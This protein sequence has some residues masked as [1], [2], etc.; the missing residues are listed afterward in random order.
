MTSLVKRLA[1][2]GPS[3]VARAVWRRAMRPWHCWRTSGAP[4]YRPPDERQLATIRADLSALGMP[5]VDYRVDPAAFAVF[6]ERFIFPADY[7]GGVD[8]PVYVEK[9]LEH[10]V[11]WDLLALDNQPGRWPYVDIA[12]ASSPWARLL[13]ERGR[14]AWSID[15]AP[16]PSLAQLP[17]YL[18]GDAT[19]SPFESGGLG[20][21]SLQCAF[22]M[23]AADADTRLVRELARVLKPNGRAVI[24]PLYMHVEACYYQSPE[25]YGR[26]IGDA[27]ARRYLRPEAWDVPVSRKYSAMTLEQRVWQPAIAA[28]LKPGLHVLRNA[29]E[30]GNSVYLHFVL[31]LDK[32]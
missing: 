23:F 29:A 2:K 3:G 7:H 11:A 28:G 25:H 14:E 19:S 15:L 20:S 8:A 18:R 1:E 31:T 21:A 32:P 27:G 26:D 22:E 17:Y 16:H 5:S 12:G 4:V 10:F 13:R 30:F 6:R 9:L 24:C